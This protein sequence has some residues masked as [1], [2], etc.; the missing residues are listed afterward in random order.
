MLSPMI[1]TRPTANAHPPARPRRRAFTLVELLVV[2]GIIALLV[3]ILLPALA[4]ARR[5][6]NTVTCA[7]NLRTILQAMHLYA[8]QN[9]G[10]IPG[11]AHTTARFLFRNID[12]G[13]GNTTV[14]NDN[15]CPEI[16][17]VF[18][19]ASPIAR[20]MRLGFPE[21][22]TTAQR[23]ARYEY[24]R[25]AGPFRCPEN[26]LLSTA[27]DAP[28]F[29]DGRIVSYNT[30][31]G[32]L[33]VRNPVIN[34]IPRGRDGVTH[35]R[36]EWNPPTN[37]KVRISQVGNPARK[38]YLADGARY[39]NSGTRPDASIAVFSSYG[40]AFGDQGACQRF[41]NSWDRSKAPGN[42]P[43]PSTPGDFDARLYAFRHGARTPGGKAGA[44]KLNAG[45]FDGHVETIGD[46]EFA[47]PEIWF[48]RGSEVAAT[49]SQM[50]NDVINRYFNGQERNPW[51]VP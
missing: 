30:A 27:F 32:F 31:I 16:I 6:A 33:V 2:I 11:S 21:G 10:A 3:A 34:N 44:Y 5:A 35:G 19:W 28:A 49:R 20:I 22:A 48:P 23:V 13:L 4:G 24:L 37:Y 15:N 9:N 29:R 7:A 25:D 8:S 45:F 38:L 1:V 39:S 41:S 43:H 18:D 12:T 26:E 17:Q 36:L 40:G 51:I 42:Q 14:F 47:N 46:I 50:H